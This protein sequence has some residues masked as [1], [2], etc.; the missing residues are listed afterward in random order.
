M[1]A[2]REQSLVDVPAI[3]R[4][5]G[6]GTNCGSCRPALANILAQ[7]PQETLHAAE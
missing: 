1:T 2:I 3:G 5:I 4:A 7:I 6:A